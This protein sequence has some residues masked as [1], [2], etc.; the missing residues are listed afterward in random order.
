MDKN[1]KGIEKNISLEE[2]LKEDLNQI[3]MMYL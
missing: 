3:S 1:L 2:Q